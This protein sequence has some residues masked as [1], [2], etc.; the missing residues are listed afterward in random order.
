MEEKK[1]TTPK[2]ESTPVQSTTTPTPETKKKSK[3]LLYVILAILAFL[4]IGAILLFFVFKN[5]F[6]TVRDAVDDTQEDSQIEQEFEQEQTEDEEFMFEA[7]TEEGVEGELES[8]SLIIDAWREDI[9]LSGGIVTSSQ[10]GVN[11]YEVKLAIASS[12]DEVFDWYVEALREAGWTVTQQEKNPPI[13]EGFTNGKISFSSDE[14]R[15][16]IDIE[17]TLYYQTTHVSIRE[18]QY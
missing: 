1:E 7:E 2:V 3:V 14:T 10:E 12:F 11:F 16:T 8:R 5:I 9:P 17:R 6:T 13:V 4:L 15:G 18:L